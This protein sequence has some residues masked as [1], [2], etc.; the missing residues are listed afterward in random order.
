[1]G[2]LKERKLG[3]NQIESRMMSKE[4]VQPKVCRCETRNRRGLFTLRVG[5]FPSSWSSLSQI[6]R[7]L[8]G[9]PSPP[10]GALATIGAEPLAQPRMDLKL[11][12]RPHS[13]KSTDEP[14]T[15][16][17]SSAALPPSHFTMASNADYKD[18]QF[19]AVIGDE[20]SFLAL[21]A[22]RAAWVPG[23]GPLT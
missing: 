15:R 12:G 6:H 16:T 21:D 13:S 4:R 10:R 2:R 23:Q 5:N 14:A 19:L 17:S 11:G 22:S 3:K 7:Q 20:V 1:M 18:R 8:Q 9:G